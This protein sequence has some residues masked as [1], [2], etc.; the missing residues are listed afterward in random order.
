MGILGNSERITGIGGATI[1][2]KVH[3]HFPLYLEVITINIASG[4]CNICKLSIN[5]NNRV[6]INQF[7][8]RWKNSDAFQSWCS[9][10]YPHFA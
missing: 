5:E 8:L 4:D 2:G 9:C 10:T 3:A 6:N 7:P 1:H